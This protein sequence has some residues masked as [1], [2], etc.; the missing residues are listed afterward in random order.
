[1][2]T[3]G[4]LRARLGLDKKKFDQGLTTAK[5]Q[6]NKFGSAMKKVGGI[7]AGAFAV[8]KIIQ[9]AKALK[10]A[11]QVQREAEIKLQTIMKQRMGLGAAAVKDLQKQASAYQK[12]GV[13]GDEVQL[14][15]LQ[16]LATFLKQKESL[17]SLLPAMN[18]LLAQQKGFNAGAQDAVNIANLMG[19]VLDGQ[20][21]ALKRTGISF[22]QAQLEALKMGNEMERAA[23][24][25]DVINS[26]VGDVNKALGKSDLGKIK[27]WQNAWGDFKELL[28]SKLVPILGK[29]AEW[30]MKTL[31][32]MSSGF[33]EARNS[34]ISLTNNFI[35]LYNESMFFRKVVQGIGFAVKTVFG[36]L[37][38]QIQSA[39]AAFK[40]LGQIV[41][42]IFTGNW[43]D[44]KDHAN[45]AGQEIVET[46][47]DYAKE[48]GE[49]WQKMMEN[50]TGKEYIQHIRIVATGG[51][52]G[53][54][55]R[56]E[57]VEPMDKISPIAGIVTDPEAMNRLIE[58]TKNLQTM[59][60]QT[61]IAALDMGGI[62]GDVFSGMANSIS[63]ALGETK[64]VFQA[65]WK[66]FTNFIKGL[67]IKLIAATIAALALAAVLSAIGM[68]GG[69]I[70][71]QIAKIGKF[72]DI[73]ASGFGQIS[74]FD[75][76]AEGAHGGV[77]PAG[78]PN[79]TYPALLS[80]GETVLTPQQSQST[81]EIKL[82]GSVNVDG[83]ILKI[84]FERGQAF[85]NDIT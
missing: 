7:L 81:N 5:K 49:N 32:K 2:K 62:I 69:K 26:N 72:K 68:G 27:A 53:T 66:F 22:T 12:I 42:D 55:G 23:V 36:F 11:Y 10:Q 13:I 64:N 74:G 14:S 47:A 39:K 6:G 61:N 56:G 75:K 1:M 70:A 16:Q 4:D 57:G 15:G 60:A 85:M 17:E 54:E 78:Y 28:G 38:A 24:L 20:T 33:Q 51:A 18:N 65:F 25:A 9:W 44:I 83:R 52:A 29:I 37:K 31:P 77:V 76:L 3:V 67:I 43:D 45:Q 59:F 40:G 46:Q 50:T 71:L 35:D 73:F 41:K 21:S 63:D 30:G 48:I 80:S 8:T 58:G 79:D 19:K 82:S 34:V 84:V